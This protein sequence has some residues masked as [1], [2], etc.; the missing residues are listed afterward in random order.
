M[1]LK[2]TKLVITEGIFDIIGVYTH[3][4]KENNDKNIIFAAACGK[5]L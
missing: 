2:R 5:G 1:L 4:Y 3:F